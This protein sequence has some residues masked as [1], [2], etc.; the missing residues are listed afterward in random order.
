MA[1]VITIISLGA[2]AS[3]F[4]LLMS[5]LSGMM[6]DP[7]MSSQLC[8][9]DRFDVAWGVAVVAPPIVFVASAIWGYRRSTHGRSGWWVPLLG[10]LLGWGVWLAAYAVMTTSIV[11]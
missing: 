9:I 11:V 8:D 3:A 4:L 6:T 1:A 10:I 2:L 7:C 5:L